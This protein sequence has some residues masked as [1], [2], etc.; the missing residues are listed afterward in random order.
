MNEIKLKIRIN[1]WW[2]KIITFTIFLLGSVIASLPT[3]NSSIPQSHPTNPQYPSYLPGRL[4]FIVGR[5]FT[6]R[7]QQQFLWAMIYKTNYVVNN[8]MPHGCIYAIF[9][10]FS[11]LSTNNQTSL[12]DQRSHWADIIYFLWHHACSKDK[13]TSS[14]YYCICAVHITPSSDFFIYQFIV[15]S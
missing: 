14:F 4:C 1:N 8:L 9:W 13:F 6:E 10:R 15:D 5:E 11:Q 3:P 2:W 12:H 7:A